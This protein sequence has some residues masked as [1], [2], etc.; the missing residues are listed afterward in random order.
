MHDGQTY[1][2]Y[3]EPFE[4]DLCREVAER[5]TKVAEQLD[6]AEHYRHL[7]TSEAMAREFNFRG[8]LGELATA[9]AF[10]KYWPARVWPKGDGAKYRDLPDVGGSIEVKSLTIL[11]N[12][13]RLRSSQKGKRLFIVAAFPE[14]EK[15]SVIL[16][17]WRAYDIA[18]DLAVPV[19]A[20]PKDREL[21]HR[22]LK[23]MRDALK[24][25]FP[26]E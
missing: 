21:N 24:H 1:T 12:P 11:S 10:N 22:H 2:V 13:V 9:K 23:P 20:N 16:L 26:G 4:L 18:F 15:S 25:F 17:G 7:Q 19:A 6:D 8:C 3:L 5:L 14:P